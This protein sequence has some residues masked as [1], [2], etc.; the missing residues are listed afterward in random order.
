MTLLYYIKGES[1]IGRKEDVP[2]IVWDPGWN[3]G[4]ERDISGKT[5]EVQS[6]GF[7]ER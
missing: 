7:P 2:I 3:P 4:T 5:A 1:G 6:S